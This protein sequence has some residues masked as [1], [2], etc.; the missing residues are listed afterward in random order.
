[1][2]RG[3]D[4]AIQK[5]FG[6]AP[7]YIGDEGGL[8]NGSW[9][10]YHI[11]TDKS[12]GDSWQKNRRA[13]KDMTDK[14]N[15]WDL[16]HG[17]M[18][19]V[20]TGVMSRLKF[21][22]ETVPVE[23]YTRE[24][25]LS[26]E[27]DCLTLADKL[28]EF[29]DDHR[30]VS[31]YDTV[32]HVTGKCKGHPVLADISWRERAEVN[33]YEVTVSGH[34][35]AVNFICDSLDKAFAHEQR[36]LI[37]WWYNRAD[38]GPQTRHVWLPPLKTQLRKEFYPDLADPQQYLKDY[39]RSEASV[40]LLAGPPGTG[41]TTL[42]RHLICENKLTAHVV[43]DE[44]IMMNDQVFQQ[45]L[46]EDTNDSIMIIEDA[47]TILLSREDDGNKL[48]SR[49]LNV[50]D[51]LIKLPNKKLVFTTNLGGADF[52]KVDEALLRPGRCFGVLHTRPLNLTEAQAAA[53]VASLPIPMEK[54][55]YTLADL[56]NRNQGGQVR[57][58]GFVR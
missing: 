25:K 33:N 35:E 15:I 12:G 58:I 52:G 41:K 10:D 20:G 8:S 5:A 9:A 57:R 24:I 27:C 40:L 42:L 55:E 21:I 47:D 50:S 16:D 38:Q 22:A 7:R 18:I 48:M 45:F 51:G 2:S 11:E 36:A 17:T 29:V 23:V 54:G 46:F 43:Y 56:F 53:K 34:R 3:R 6:D 37:K 32:M 39:L 14:Q 1:M 19:E 30:L 4:E 28:M 31:P 26:L 44:R 49:F 13:R